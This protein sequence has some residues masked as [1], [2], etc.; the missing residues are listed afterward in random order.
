MSFIP[1]I[2]KK[3]LTLVAGFLIFFANGAY[4]TF[5][6]MSPYIISYLRSESNATV[7]YSDV[8]WITLM[9]TLSGAFA[10]LFVGLLANKFNKIPIKVYL[11][12]GSL[13][14]RY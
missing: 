5:S 3:W 8:K 9:Q 2:Y 12:L 6:N 14:Y 13:M 4:Y 10:S 1:D 11:M 7:R